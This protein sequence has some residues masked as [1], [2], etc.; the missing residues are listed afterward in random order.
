[1]WVSRQGWVS[2]RRRWCSCSQTLWMC[3]GSLGG[4]ERPWIHCRPRSSF[5][6]API[7]TQ[8]WTL[9]LLSSPLC[10]S[11]KERPWSC[12]ANS[13]RNPEV[14]MSRIPLT[15]YMKWFFNVKLNLDVLSAIIFLSS[16]SDQR[17][18]G[19]SQEV[20][21]LVV[22]AVHFYERKLRD[23]YTHLR[24][25][26]CWRQSWKGLK[27]IL[28]WPYFGFKPNVWTGDAPMLHSGAVASAVPSQCE[29]QWFKILHLWKMHFLLL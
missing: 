15:L 29:E 4:V 22:Q 27:Q 11:V 25:V 1:M 13:A 18:S 6:V 28:K 17:C 20:V 5:T 8:L 7:K 10:S 19:D 14:W 9:T 12:S 3:R 2:W 24:Y 21:R 16:S 26:G 23:F